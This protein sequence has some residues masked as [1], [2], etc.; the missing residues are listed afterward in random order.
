MRFV[1]GAKEYKLLRPLQEVKGVMSR[2]CSSAQEL[3]FS[4]AGRDDEG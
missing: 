3:Q 2:T 1:F 4:L